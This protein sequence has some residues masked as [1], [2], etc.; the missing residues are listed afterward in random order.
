L[1]NDGSVWGTGFN[2]PGTLGDGTNTNRVSPVQSPFLTN[3]IEI[4]ANGWHSLFLKNDATVWATGYNSNGQL[5]DGT[6]INR[7]TPVQV[8]IPCNAQIVTPIQD[9]VIKNPITV[10]PNPFSIKMIL[11]SEYSLKDATL[12]IYNSIGQ[13]M[14]QIKNISGHTFTF[15]RGTL[16]LGIYFYLLTENDKIITME[17][18]V[19]VD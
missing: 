15:F 7:S 6:L 13:T 3:I 2:G 19:I 18:I 14:K 10:Y 8:L 11:Q 4:A 1:K 9:K 12:T 5:G 17:K 16:P